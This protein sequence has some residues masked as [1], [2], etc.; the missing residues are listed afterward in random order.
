MFIALKKPNQYTFHIH[1]QRDRQKN[2]DDK[3][4]GQNRLK[5]KCFKVNNQILFRAII[6]KIIIIIII[7]ARVEDLD[8]SNQANSH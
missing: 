7:S 5:R 2:L 4:K 3:P 6:S 1:L 8:F